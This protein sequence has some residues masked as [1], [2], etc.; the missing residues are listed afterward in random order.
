MYEVFDD[1]LS[2]SSWTSCHSLDLARF[3]RALSKVVGE[4]GFSPEAMGGYMKRQKNPNF[5]EEI[6]K[7]VA[8]AWAVSEY[9]AATE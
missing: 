1:F 4:D 7:L 5:H 6:D 3:Y 8:N 2:L 9:L